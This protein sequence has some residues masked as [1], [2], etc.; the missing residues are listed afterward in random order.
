MIGGSDSAGIGPKMD[1]NAPTAW[2]LYLGLHPEVGE[3]R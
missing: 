3:T 1:P 2:S